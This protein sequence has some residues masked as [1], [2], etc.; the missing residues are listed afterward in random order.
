MRRRRVWARPSYVWSQFAIEFWSKSG[1][2]LDQTTLVTAGQGII[3]SRALV[4]DEGCR[5][6]G[7]WGVGAGGGVRKLVYGVCGGSNAGGAEPGSWGR[8]T[9]LVKNTWCAVRQHVDYLPT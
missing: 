5:L 6:G 2:A 1:V 4:H 9:A 8:E 7:L 3:T